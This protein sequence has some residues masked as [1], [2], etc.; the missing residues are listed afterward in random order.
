VL[1][2]EDVEITVEKGLVLPESLVVTDLPLREK[3]R[4]DQVVEHKFLGFWLIHNTT[5]SSV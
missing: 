2:L 5:G 1:S 3:C 4:I